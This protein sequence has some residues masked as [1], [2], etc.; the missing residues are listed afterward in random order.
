MNVPSPLDCLRCR[1]PMEFLG[2]RH[3]QTLAA[4]ESYYLYRCGRCGRV[5]FFDFLAEEPADETECLSCG[6]VIP[7]GEDDCAQCGWTWRLSSGPAPNI[8]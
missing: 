7:A 5:E 6:A 1:N 2:R 4:S 3:Y 8:P